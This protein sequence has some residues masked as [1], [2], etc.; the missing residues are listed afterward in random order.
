MSDLVAADERIH[1]AGDGALWNDSLYFNCY[2]PS[3]EVG[4]VTRIGILPN[5]G[6]AN[7][8]MLAFAGAEVAGAHVRVEERP[9]GDWDDLAVGG[10]RYRVAGPFVR[11]EIVS[12]VEGM[13]ASLEVTPFTPAVSYHGVHGN[14]TDTYGVAA[15]HYEQS[16][17]VTGWV[18][19]GGERVALEGWGQRDHS[20]G[21]RDWSGVEWWYWVSPV[22]GDDLSLN[23]FK[24]SGGGGTSTGGMLWMAGTAAPVVSAEIEVE[25]DAEGRQ[26]RARVRASDAEARTIEVEGTR[27]ALASL[28]A[29]TAVVEEAFFRFTH[30]DRTGFGIFEYL[31][32]P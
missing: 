1:P 22:F 16:C 18:E 27:I 28:P 17:R 25:S 9:S 30:G 8:L 29:G 5:Q 6:Q 24:A 15:G 10:V 2:D 19:I 11:C 23:V 31:R 12:E 32:R 3:K 7:V 13:K 14:L 4:I 26:Q 21:I 20:W